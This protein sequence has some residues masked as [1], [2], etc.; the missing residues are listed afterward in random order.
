MRLHEKSAKANAGP[1]RKRG[2][3]KIVWDL[4]EE[5]DVDV[6]EVAKTQPSSSARRGAGRGRGS[7]T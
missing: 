5:S 3:P 6:A 4:H 1:P 7:A 2:Q